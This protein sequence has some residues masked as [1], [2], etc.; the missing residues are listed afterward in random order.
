MIDSFFQKTNQPTNKTSSKQ[1]RPVGD[2]SM[3][4]YLAKSYR[5]LTILEYEIIAK[6]DASNT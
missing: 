2:T 1:L 3:I 5:I 6:E 4:F